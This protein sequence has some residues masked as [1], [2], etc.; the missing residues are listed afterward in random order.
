MEP[1][2]QAAAVDAAG[3]TATTGAVREAPPHR[4]EEF[5]E[6]GLQGVFAYLCKLHATTRDQ[7]LHPFAFARRREAH[8]REAN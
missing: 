1:Q 2:A 4:I 6:G 7:L 5:V 3:A 8:L